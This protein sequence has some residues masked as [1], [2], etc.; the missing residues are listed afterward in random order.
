MDTADALWQDLSETAVKEAYNIGRLGLESLR[1][2]LGAFD[3]TLHAWVRGRRVMTVGADRAAL[4]FLIS[5]AAASVVVV[6]SDAERVAAA[7]VPDDPENLSC[8]R[9]DLSAL[10]F[11][12]GSFDVVVLP[13]AW[14]ESGGPAADELARVLSSDGVAVLEAPTDARGPWAAVF[15]H[16]MGP[17]G[18]LFDVLGK[19]PAA[20]S[21][22][23]VPD[24]D[25]ERTLARLLIERE[26][27]AELHRDRERLTR[28]NRLL[29]Q[30]AVR[31]GAAEARLDRLQLERAAL[32]GAARRVDRETARAALAEVREQALREERD[33]LLA[34]R[35]ALLERSDRLAAVEASRAWRLTRRYWRAMDE[36]SALRGVRRATLR[37]AGRNPD[38]GAAN[39]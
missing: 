25:A 28:H 33:A 13:A 21:R 2:A 9:A 23:A 32:V 15:P 34:E 35:G 37:L 6:D 38:S 12:E 27:R 3:L 17:A 16:R 4:W 30:T 20:A 11:D 5:I 26:R 29:A 39:P 24:S 18:A 1:E 8:R 22:E 31:V 7:A 36:S 14:L 10:P 19:A